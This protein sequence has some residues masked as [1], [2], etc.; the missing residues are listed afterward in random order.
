MQAYLDQAVQILREG[1][2]QIN[3]P[4]G[5]II[6]LAA[7]IFLRSWKQW[8]PAAIVAVLIHIAIEHFA[9]MLAGQ[10][11]IAL[12]PLMEAPFWNRVGV[13]LVGYLV[14]IGIFFFAKRILMTAAGAGGKAKAH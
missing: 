12:P 4:K 2:A 10:S 5:L 6:A 9:P 8:I 14:V 13:L 7:T 11:A 3:D 1:F